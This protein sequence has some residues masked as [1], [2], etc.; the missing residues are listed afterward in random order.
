MA[1]VP[2]PIFLTFRLTVAFLE[3]YLARVLLILFPALPV[4][5]AATL[6]LSSAPFSL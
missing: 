6:K 5:M 4:R 2:V 1:E 3:G